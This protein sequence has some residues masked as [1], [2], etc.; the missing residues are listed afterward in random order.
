MSTSNSYVAFIMNCNSP[1][2][3][4]PLGKWSFRLSLI[5]NFLKKTFSST[6]YTLFL[7]SLFWKKLKNI[8]YSF[9]LQFWFRTTNYVKYNNNLSNAITVLHH[10]GGTLEH[11]IY[12]ET[13]MLWASRKLPEN[14]T[15]N[16]VT[17][18]ICLYRM[19][20]IESVNLNSLIIFFIT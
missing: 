3:Q 17:T 11:N 10:I 5:A 12:N 4:T 18:V 8:L 20:E 7:Y 14:A 16:D 1:S 19:Y 9:K 6:L 15:I 2:W 13:L